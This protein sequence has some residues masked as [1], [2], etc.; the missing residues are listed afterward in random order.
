MAEHDTDPVRRADELR[1]T[2]LRHNRALPRA[3][4]ARGPR[5]RVRRAG[6]RAAGARGASSPSSSRPTRPPSGWAARRRTL[7]APVAHRV[8]MMSLDNAFSVDE[9][10]GLGRAAARR[11]RPGRARRRRLR[12]RAEDRRRSPSRSATRT[13]ASCR[14][15][16][17]ATAASGEDVTAN[18][19][20]DRRRARAPADGRARRCSRCAARSTCRCAAFEALNERAGRG[21]RAARSPTPATPRPARCARRTRRSPPA[22]S[23]RSGRYQLGEVEG[24]PAFTSHHETL[25]CL[26]GARA[27]RSTPRSRVRRRLDEVYAYCRALAGAPP[28]PR[29]RDRRRGREGR[30]PRPARASSASRRKAP[31]W[32]IAY[33]FPPEERTTTLLDIMVSIGRTGRATPFAVLEPVFVGGVHRRARPRCTT[34]TRCAAKDVRP[35]DTVIVRKAGDVI[36]EVVGPG[37]RR[38]ARRARAVG[39]PDRPARAC[40]EPLVRPEGESR[41]ALRQ[42]RLP[43]PARRRA[44]S[45]SPSAGRMDIEGFGEQRVRLFARARARARRRRHLHARLGRSVARARGLRRGLGRATCWPPSRRRRTARCAN[46]L[47]GLNIRHLG[48]AGAEALAPALRPPRR[49]SWTRR[50]TSIAAVE[51]VGPIIA[52]GGARAG[53]PTSA[54]RALVEKLRAAGRRTS[55][56]PSAP[57]APQILAGMSVVVTGTLEGYSREEAEAAITERATWTC[58]PTALPYYRFTRGLVADVPMLVAR[59]GYSGELGYELFFPRE[60]AEHVWDAAFAAGEPF[61]IAAVRTRRPAFGADGEEVPALR[62][63]PERTTSPLEASLGWTVRFEKGEFIGRDALA[64]QRDDGVTRRLV[65]IELGAGDPLPKAGDEITADGT[66]VGSVTSSDIGHAL[67]ARSRWVCRPA[68]AVEGARVSVVSAETGEKSQRRRPASRVLRPR[69][70]AP[71]PPR[72]SRVVPSPPR[73]RPT[74]S[75]ERSRSAGA[76]RARGRAPRRRDIGPAGRVDGRGSLGSLARPVRARLEQ[77]GSAL[78]AQPG[79]PRPVL[80]PAVHEDAHARVGHD[81]AHAGQLDEDPVASACRRWRRTGWPASGWT[82]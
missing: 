76:A 57:A 19:A 49:A 17:A 43:G 31:R 46:L 27:S 78:A 82:A 56:G 80:V 72:A 67:G 54:N 47:V 7:F 12:L 48:P 55:S 33:K 22:A 65:G 18:V 34:R 29:L 39:V 28:R 8:P 2:I 16:P 66:A 42:R 13:A 64:R 79:Q 24:G 81:V 44:S 45:T 1:A 20:H 9:L 5:R 53:S 60:Y 25:E 51:G 36:P 11:R 38:A 75:F 23:C 73:G 68:G 77:G 4:R 52:A 50:S 14:R 58:P 63:R 35:G 62:A 15:P 70:A 6:P 30:R 69:P 59:T 37:A 61:G 41:H 71:E 40:G 3:R 26:R 21:R 10:R 32:A 74:P